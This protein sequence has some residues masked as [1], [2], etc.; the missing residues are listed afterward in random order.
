MNDRNVGNAD[1]DD[2]RPASPATGFTPPA[3]YTP[4]DETPPWIVS[5]PP[6]VGYPQAP[7]YPPQQGPAYPPQQGPG[8]PPQ[9]GPYPPPQAGYPPPEAG[10]PPPGGGF[11]PP[12]AG[13][14]PSTGGF[15]VPNGG[16]QLA[17]GGYPE[18][19]GGYPRTT[20][21]RRLALIVG[22]VL[23]LMLAGGGAWYL[24]GRT[25]DNPVPTDASATGDVGDGGGGA[26]VPPTVEDTEETPTY[27]DPPTE[28]VTTDP[29]TD[30]TDDP[31]DDPTVDPEQA[32]VDQLDQIAEQ[33]LAQVTLDNRYVAQIASKYPGI[34]D[35]IQTTESGSHTFQ[36]TDILAEYQR[37]RS[38]PGNGSA[39]IVLLKST[40]FGKRQLV[41]NQPLYVTFAI[42]NFGSAQAVRSWCARRFPGLSGNAL[43]DQCAVRRLRPPQ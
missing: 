21:N 27:S 32:A 40:D 37:L 15:Q 30:P 31:T 11:P 1:G 3:S 38:G 34:D 22:L 16:Y 17:G 14:P 26:A 28:D 20:A 24:F 39:R 2:S 41:D 18:P 9:A 36:A 25:P 35:P 4:T 8:Y 42:G 7:G 10:Y 33:D 23:V 29:T 12:G 43:A 5:A 13:Y 19:A 6:T